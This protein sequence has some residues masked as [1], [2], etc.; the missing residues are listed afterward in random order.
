MPQSLPDVIAL[1]ERTP[2]TLNALL[3]NLPQSWT[4]ANDGGDTWTP[5]QIVAHSIDSERHNWIA[6]AQLILESAATPTFPV[7]A[8]AGHIAE[9]E[10]KTLPQLLDLFADLRRQNLAALHALHLKPVDLERTGIHPAFGPVTLGNLLATWAA[11]DLT[12]L[13]QLSRTL[14][15][16]LREDV[17]PWTAYLGVMK[18]TGHSS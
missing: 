3:R 2:A 6:R 15:H 12:H 10:G 17:G 9:A 5:L 18:C 16:Q 1:L 4:L 7:F 14:A 13:H 11:H 8:R